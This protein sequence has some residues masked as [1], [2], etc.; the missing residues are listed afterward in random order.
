MKLYREIKASERLPKKDAKVYTDVGLA[1]YC[2]NDNWIVEYPEDGGFVFGINVV[3][4]WLEPIDLPED[5]ESLKLKWQKHN[6]DNGLSWN[7]VAELVNEVVALSKPK[8]NG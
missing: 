4:W 5:I 7:E 6:R 3:K 8:G 1:D 2:G